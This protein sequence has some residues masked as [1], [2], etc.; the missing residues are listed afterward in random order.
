[1]RTADPAAEHFDYDIAFDIRDLINLKDAQQ[2]AQLGPNG[3]G[4]M[5]ATILAALQIYQLSSC[6]RRGLI[7]CMEYLEDNLDD[8][9]ADEL[10]VRGARLLSAAHWV[11]RATLLQH[12]NCKPTHGGPG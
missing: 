10:E 2:E 11:S 5:H 9:L 3:Y 6:R 4:C 12:C 1:M 7:F 8:W